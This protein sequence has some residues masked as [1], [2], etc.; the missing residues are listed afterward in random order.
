VGQLAVVLAVSA[1]SS[2]RPAAPP[3]A[4]GAYRVGLGDVLEIRVAGRQELTRSPTVQPSGA[5]SMPLVGRVRVAGLTVRGI[6]SELASRLAEAHIADPRV[7]V[8][9]VEYRSQRIL[10]LGEVNF[11]GRK[12]LGSRFRVADVLVAAGG[13]THDASGELVI[14][15][16]EQ[17]QTES[18]RE[19]SLKLDRPPTVKDQINLQVVVQNGDVIRAL[20]RYHV[21]VWGEVARPGDFTHEEGLTVSRAVAQAGGLTRFA[22]ARVKVHRFHDQSGE[23]SI[24]EADLTAIRDGQQPDLPLLPKDVVEVGSRRF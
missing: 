2:P 20:P 22:D 12:R 19:L 7:A 13:F 15:R 17:T 3:A 18:R 5:I 8:K 6:E 23:V 10:V 16:S 24:L 1:A 21:G 11:P 9:V 4:S 14:E